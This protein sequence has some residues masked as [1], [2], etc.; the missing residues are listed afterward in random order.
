MSQR[1]LHTRFAHALPEKVEDPVIRIKKK[2]GPTLNLEMGR[3]SALAIVE[4][5][6]PVK[7]KRNLPPSTVGIKDIKCNSSTS[8]T[9]GFL[10]CFIL[11]Y[12]FRAS[13]NILAF[14]FPLSGK[15]EDNYSNR[16]CGINSSSLWVRTKG[17]GSL[18]DDRGVQLT[19]TKISNSNNRSDRCLELEGGAHLGIGRGGGD[20]NRRGDRLSQTGQ[21]L[22]VEALV[23][24][25]CRVK[26]NVQVAR[27]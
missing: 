10:F 24:P 5:D 20:N 15:H 25:R 18:Y 17:G 7:F 13:I 6:A 27:T 8:R 26:E 23:E 2:R 9:C 11:F 3:Q 19:S 4:V 1:W 12:I 21:G 14:F 22:E 16:D